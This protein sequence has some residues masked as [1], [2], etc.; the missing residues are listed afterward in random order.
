MRV[1]LDALVRRSVS[2]IGLIALA[3]AALVAALGAQGRQAAPPPPSG[4]LPQVVAGG[5]QIANIV[6]PKDDMMSRPFN[7]ENGTKLVLWVKM[8][9]GQGL[10]EIDDDGSLLQSFS[11]DK[12]T[13][14]G[15]RIGSFPDEFKDGSGG[16]VEISSTGLPAAG[17][18]RLV[19]E[20]T[21]ALNVSSGVKPERV[22]NVSIQNGRTFLLGK[23]SI[24][25]AEVETSGAEQKFTLKLPRVVM[26][27]IRDVKFFDAKGQAL[28][29][30]RSGTGYMNDAGE[31]GLTVTTAL[32]T[33]T[34]EFEVW[35]G[36]RTIKVP[37][38]VQTGL[39]VGGVTP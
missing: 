26:E 34:L 38:K 23:T 32:K 39:G 6:A 20:G 9:A 2:R 36:R 11:D 24:T 35:Q 4:P 37:F 25:V 27:G 3:S 13:N 28:E 33:L 10:I 15:G 18:T 16:T 19:A 31:M 8:P 22:A 21:L 14:L 17:A 1:L 12:G 29:G 7:S 5:I 30:H